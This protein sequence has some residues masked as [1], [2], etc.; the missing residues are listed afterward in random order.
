MKEVKAT[1]V[2]RERLL[3]GGSRMKAMRHSA[4]PVFDTWGREASMAAV[5]GLA[6][7]RQSR[8]GFWLLQ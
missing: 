6:L 2:P 3:G 1:C 5:K 4:L 8:V 7:S